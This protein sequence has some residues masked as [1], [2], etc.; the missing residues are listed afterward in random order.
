MTPSSDHSESRIAI[1]KCLKHERYQLYFLVAVGLCMK[2]AAAARSGVSTMFI[3]TRVRSWPQHD[4]RL[5]VDFALLHA[6]PRTIGRLLRAFP[7]REITLV[8][9]DQK[10][11]PSPGSP[12]RRS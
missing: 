7:Q 3:L 10:L 2:T 9:S 5:R 12:E 11:G 4:R 6:L 8:V 1:E